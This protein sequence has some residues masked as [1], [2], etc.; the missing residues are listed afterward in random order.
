[1][2]VVLV[3]HGANLS[4]RDKQGKT[5][6]Q[7]SVL[8]G[9]EDVQRIC[10]H[11]ENIPDDVDLESLKNIRGFCDSCYRVSVIPSPQNV[12]IVIL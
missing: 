11:D 4:S 5:P 1:M 2:A 8:S 10:R 7:L 6:Y 12:L 3:N 9:S